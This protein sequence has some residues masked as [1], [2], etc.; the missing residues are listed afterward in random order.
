MAS[1]TV[2]SYKAGDEIVKR[3]ELSRYVMAVVEGRAACH[4]DNPEH[5]ILLYYLYPGD[6]GT[7]ALSKELSPI[8]SMVSFKADT[9]CRVGIV[10]ADVCNEVKDRCPE[11][12]RLMRKHFMDRFSDLVYVIQEKSFSPARRIIASYLYERVLNGGNRV[13]HIS[14][15]EI[16][17]DTD[18]SRSLVSTELAALE[19]M[20]IIKKGRGRIHILDLAHLGNI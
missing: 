14:H 5:P 19:L 6:F 16:A 13:I 4:L 3:D 9:D 10:R 2:R 12:S 7:I 18:F 8:S 15:S 1:Y 11:L 20:G 17:Q